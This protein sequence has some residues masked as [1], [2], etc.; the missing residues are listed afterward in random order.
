MKWSFNKDQKMNRKSPLS[1]A[2]KKNYYT[3]H[4]YFHKSELYYDRAS[5]TLYPHIHSPLYISFCLPNGLTLTFKV[6]AYMSISHCCQ[7]YWTYLTGL[8]ISHL[9][10]IL[11][12]C[13][14]TLHRYFHPKCLHYAL[15]SLLLL[16]KFILRSL[17]LIQLLL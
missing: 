9:A 10:S 11:S 3:S 17:F 12:Y 16:V 2:Q 8:L 14:Y 7:I 4:W 13:S 1:I 15:S 6:T 5:S